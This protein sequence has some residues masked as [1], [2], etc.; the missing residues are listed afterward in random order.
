M[1]HPGSIICPAQEMPVAAEP[2][3]REDRLQV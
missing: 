1:N 2:S 3:Q